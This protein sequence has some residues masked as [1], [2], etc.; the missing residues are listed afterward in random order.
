MTC[1]RSPPYVPGNRPYASNPGVDKIL[2]TT[3]P[4][5][6]QAK[7]S[8]MGFIELD[9]FLFMD[10]PTPPQFPSSGTD[11]M[12]RNGLTP[13]LRVMS[14]KMK[15]EVPAGESKSSFYR[16]DKPDLSRI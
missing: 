11:V 4:G 14:R 3:A 5:H 1:I 7:P 15:A 2:I 16:S 13:K 10:V 8:R 9:L 6:I 12:S